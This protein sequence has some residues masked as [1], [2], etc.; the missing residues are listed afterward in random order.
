ME[1]GPGGMPESEASAATQDPEKTDENGGRDQLGKFVSGGAAAV[2]CGKKGRGPQLA[3]VFRD[4]WDKPCRSHPITHAL[5]MEYKVDPGQ[6]IREL[7]AWYTTFKGFDGAFNF[8]KEAM[9]RDSGRP[10]YVSKSGDD[11]ELGIEE[12]L[13]KFRAA[14]RPPAPGEEARGDAQATNPAD[15]VPVVPADV[16][17][18]EP[19]SLDGGDDATGDAAGDVGNP[20]PIESEEKDGGVDGTGGDTEPGLDVDPDRGPGGRTEEEASEGGC[21]SAPII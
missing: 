14:T 20:I 1:H 17:A 10:A 2:E 18:G 12:Y 9:T 11:E 7:V 21:Y 8:L 4:I 15:A 13:A 5:A 16:A 6:S 3:K 19:V